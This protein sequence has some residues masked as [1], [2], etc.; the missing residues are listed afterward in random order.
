MSASAP[1]VRP[2]RK[3]APK[4]PEDTAAKKMLDNHPEHAVDSPEVAA[5]QM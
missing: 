2:T 1:Q 4:G 3:A 5:D